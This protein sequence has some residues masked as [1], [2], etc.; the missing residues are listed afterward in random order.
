[1]ADNNRNPQQQNDQQRPAPGQQ[2][3]QGEPRQDEQ[4][5]NPGGQAN[6]QEENVRRGDR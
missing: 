3:R 1:M 5:R 4:G 2:Q 6:P